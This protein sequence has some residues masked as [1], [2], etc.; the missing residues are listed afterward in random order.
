MT[1]HMNWSLSF[2]P[3][4]PTA[5]STSPPPSPPHLMLGALSS[6][7]CCV[8]IVHISGPIMGFDSPPQALGDSDKTHESCHPECSAWALLSRARNVDMRRRSCSLPYMIDE[9]AGA[10]TSNDNVAHFESAV[11]PPRGRACP[12]QGGVTGPVG[13]RTKLARWARG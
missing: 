9:R 2:T 6:N 5:S 12:T 10:R 4:A 7:A 8:S 3:K 13:V 11:H 1:S